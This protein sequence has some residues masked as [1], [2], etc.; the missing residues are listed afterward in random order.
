MGGV[1]R[2]WI[3][4]QA[5]ALIIGGGPP[6]PKMWAIPCTMAVNTVWMTVGGTAAVMNV[7]I[8]AP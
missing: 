6:R 8:T 2:K 4:W 1:C 7:L 3:S 5:Y